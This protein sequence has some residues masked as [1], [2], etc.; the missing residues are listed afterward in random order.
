MT[1][2]TIK[3]IRH[4]Y[5]FTVEYDK[6]QE[7]TKLISQAPAMLKLLQE[8]Q[9]AFQHVDGDK[10]GNQTRTDI[11]KNCPEFRQIA[12]DARTIIEKATT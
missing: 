4:T 6:L 3:P 12:V 1:T 10:T 11:F 2:Q 5:L 8:L 9:K 7:V